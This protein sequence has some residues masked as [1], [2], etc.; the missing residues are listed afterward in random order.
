MINDNLISTISTEDYNSI[1]NNV[2]D[3]MTAFNSPEKSIQ[4]NY[5][6]KREHINR[7]VGFT[8]VLTRSLELEPDVVMAAQLAALLHDIGRFEQYKQFQTF[9]DSISFDH[10]EKA[11]ELI[12]NNKWLANLPDEVQQVIIKAIKYHNKISTPKNE[13]EQSSLL[14]KVLRDADKIDILDIAVKEFSL[15]VKDQNHSFALE[16]EKKPSFSKK[17]T[18]AIIAGKNADKKELKTVNDFKLMLMSY[19]FD[20]NFKPSY[21]LINKRQ[22]LKQLFDTLPKSDDIFEVYRKTKIHVENQL[23]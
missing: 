21:A 3:Y 22:Y 12:D 11:V 20:I 23:I 19:V 15:P 1:C 4:Q 8:E 13:D 10:A 6:L 7:V 5:L 18:N 14:I 17:I 9:N 2:F 16:L